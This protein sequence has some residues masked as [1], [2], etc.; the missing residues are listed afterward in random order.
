VGDGVELFTPYAGFTI[1][2]ARADNF[3][4]AWAYSVFGTGMGK[5]VLKFK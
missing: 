4:S 1:T 3:L 5:R 2:A